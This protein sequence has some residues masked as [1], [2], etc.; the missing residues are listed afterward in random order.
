MDREYRETFTHSY[1][2]LYA[3]M[4]EEFGSEL[5]YLPE[6]LDS[7]QEAFDHLWVNGE[8][9]IFSEH[10]IESGNHLFAQFSIL[11]DQLSEFYRKHFSDEVFEENTS[12]F[13]DE[14]ESLK[15]NV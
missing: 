13:M 5:G 11:R 8:K 9:Y 12:N 3:Q 14:L 6:V 2:V 10:V 7:A 1:K 4:K 15:G